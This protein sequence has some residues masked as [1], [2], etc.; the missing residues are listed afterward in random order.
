MDKNCTNDSGRWSSLFQ[1]MGEIGALT[2]LTRKA[3]N[4][5]TG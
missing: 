1:S 5:N 2:P 4:M 3:Q